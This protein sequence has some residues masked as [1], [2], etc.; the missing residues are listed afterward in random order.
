MSAA[1]A[2]SSSSQMLMRVAIMR[3]SPEVPEW[4]SEA[5]DVLNFRVDQWEAGMR[6]HR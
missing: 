6:P 1:A 5:K 3:F 2:A 4:I